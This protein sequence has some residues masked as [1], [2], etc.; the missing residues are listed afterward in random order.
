MELKFPTF[1]T[2]DEVVFALI[3]CQIN[4][5]RLLDCSFEHLLDL[6]SLKMLQAARNLVHDLEL[7]KLRLEKGS[8]V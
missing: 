7:N 2:I 1:S 8:W 6:M 4:L 5:L 3:Q